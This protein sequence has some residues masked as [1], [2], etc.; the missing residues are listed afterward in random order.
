MKPPSKR[1]LRGTITLR[2]NVYVSEPAAIATP[3]AIAE[4]V[5]KSLASYSDGREEVAIEAAC[6]LLAPLVEH[7]VE[8]TGEAAFYRLHGNAMTRKRN[9][10]RTA[11]AIVEHG[12]AT[13]GRRPSAYVTAAEDGVVV[14]LSED[15]PE[16]GA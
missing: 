6:A 14:E 3:K 5:R 11:R 7:S 16:E 4:H 10:S 13:R 2:F 12:K 8:R 1:H 9:G 15:A